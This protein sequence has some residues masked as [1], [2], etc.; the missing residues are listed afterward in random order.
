MLG[1]L[2]RDKKYFINIFSLLQAFIGTLMCDSDL[3]SLD[4]LS[5]LWEALAD[6]GGYYL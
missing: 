3:L 2:K 6:W 5:E 1:V 4:W